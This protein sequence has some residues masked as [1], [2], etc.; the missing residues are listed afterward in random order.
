MKYPLDKYTNNDDQNNPWNIAST[1]NSILEDGSIDS[2]PFIIQKPNEDTNMFADYRTALLAMYLSLIGMFKEMY[3]DIVQ[4]Y[5][6]DTVLTAQMV[7]RR[8][9]INRDIAASAGESAITNTR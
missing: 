3:T 4:R 7:N 8:Y 2:K 5:L 1:Y 9:T 6:A